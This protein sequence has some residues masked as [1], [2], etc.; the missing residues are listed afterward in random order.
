M[1]RKTPEQFLCE[2][3][4]SLSREFRWWK[5]T[6]EHGCQDPFWA[7]GCNLN[8]IRNHIEYFKGEIRRLCEQNGLTL[9]DIY[10]EPTPPEV[11]N[12]Y[13]ANL[14]QTERVKRLTEFGDKLTT[15]KAVAYNDG[16]RTFW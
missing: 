1:G 5:S 7:D 13:M 6:Y 2:S 12:N 3:M 15:N 11:P 4:E 9:P 16:Q 8:L 14:D 10:Y